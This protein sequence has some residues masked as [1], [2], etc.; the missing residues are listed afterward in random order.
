MN[1]DIFW[2]GS[3]NLTFR[4]NATRYLISF[5]SPLISYGVCRKRTYYFCTFIIYII[6]Y[7]HEQ[8]QIKSSEKELRHFA[9]YRT[10]TIIFT[11]LASGMVIFTVRIIFFGVL[12]KCY[13][14]TVSH[15]NF[16]LEFPYSFWRTFFLRV[17]YVGHKYTPNS[18][19]SIT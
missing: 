1:I 11:V 15:S 9:F 10:G 14:I 4:R 18:V 3:E 6:E 13:K 2:Y 5:S 12:R 8:T 7:Q 19:S 16:Y 17:P